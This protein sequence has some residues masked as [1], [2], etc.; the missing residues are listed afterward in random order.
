MSAEHIGETEGEYSVAQFYSDGMN[1]Y[2]RRFVGPEEAVKA[3]EHYTQSIGV[4]LGMV[5][6]VI[7]TD[8]L[9]LTCMEWK[10]GEGITFGFEKE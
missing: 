3:F 7:I 2:V 4:K 5:D 8:A 10:N 6:R 9:D 1:E